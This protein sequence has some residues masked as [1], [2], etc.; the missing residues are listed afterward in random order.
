MTVQVVPHSLLGGATVASDPVVVTFGESKEADGTLRLGENVYQTNGTDAPMQYLN[1]HG[2]TLQLVSGSVDGVL[3][4]ESVT[5]GVRTDHV[6]ISVNGFGGVVQSGSFQIHAE[7]TNIPAAR[8]LF[9]L[10]AI[11]FGNSVGFVINSHGS[12][13]FSFSSDRTLD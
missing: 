10:G 4:G 11:G 9:L 13:L 8:I 6:N 3:Y 1:K 2:F 7:L 5:F 12:L